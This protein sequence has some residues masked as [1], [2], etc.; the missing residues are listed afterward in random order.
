MFR[1]TMCCAPADGKALSK[2]GECVQVPKIILPEGA[3]TRMDEYMQE[4][5]EDYMAY[6]AQDALVTLMYGSRLWGVNKDW[7]LTSTSGACFAMKSSIAKYMNIPSVKGKID[8][9][10][11]SF[12]CR[13]F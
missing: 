5:P 4:H 10:S 11:F 9:V 2:L 12:L 3:I 1:D 13:W 6:A 8:K 7:P